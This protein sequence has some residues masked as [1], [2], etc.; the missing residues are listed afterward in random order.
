MIAKLK[1]LFAT[2]LFFATVNCQDELSKA[3]N[4]FSSD[5]YK[6]IGKANSGKN[7]FFSPFSISTAFAMVS[8]GANGT[9]KEQMKDVL[10]LNELGSDNEMKEAY[11]QLLMS[12][13]NQTNDYVLNFVN[14]LFGSKV[15]K[16]LPRFLQD[17]QTYFGASL[18]SLDFV[19]EPDES[20]VQ[21]N[22]WVA[23]ETNQK[24]TNLLPSGSITPNTK[25]VVVNA[26]YLNA[27]WVFPFDKKLTKP[28][29][30]RIPKSKP[31]NMDMMHL[32][33]KFLYYYNSSRLCCEF[34]ELFY[35]GEKKISMFIVLPHDVDGLPNVEKQLNASVL[36]DVAN[37]LERRN[38]NVQLPKFTIEQSIS[39]KDRLE[40]LGMRDVFDES[41]ADLSGIGSGQLV[42]TDAVHKAFVSVTESGTE[43]AAATGV[44][45]GVTSAGPPPIKFIVDR[46][47]FFLIYDNSAKIV[48]FIGRLV[49]PPK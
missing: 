9:T 32:N 34:L 1:W 47:F 10:H 45:V 41:K 15:F 23:D 28:G 19:N 5:L 30:F 18:E 2:W 17:I 42:I 3:N 24:I 4:E 14:R 36:N 22:E 44:V 6:E 7:I 37:K 31:V 27:S 26:I 12:F 49:S 43:A 33:N 35:R 48:L 13:E 8:L 21:I 11:K 20:R 39:L 16:F 38:V 25:L 46:P 40:M 29:P